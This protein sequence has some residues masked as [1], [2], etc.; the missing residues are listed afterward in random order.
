MMHWRDLPPD[1]QNYPVVIIEDRY[2]GCY[3]H[4]KWIAI[5]QAFDCATSLDE[6]TCYFDIVRENAL[7]DDVTTSNWWYDT[8]QQDP[9]W[10][11]VGN[12]PDEAL[13]NLKKRRG[14]E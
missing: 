5:A 2:G 10:L 7:A 4:G 14:Q 12:T 8:L 9:D 1:I 6:S 13:A 11:A 3:S